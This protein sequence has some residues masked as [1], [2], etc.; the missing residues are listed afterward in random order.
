MAVKNI[1][2][3]MSDKKLKLYAEVSTNSRRINPYSSLDINTKK[4]IEEAKKWAIKWSDRKVYSLV[5]ELSN[6]EK[7]AYID[8]DLES[9]NIKK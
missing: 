5:W 2:E 9:R 7:L 8:I 1:F 4:I 6:E 3:N